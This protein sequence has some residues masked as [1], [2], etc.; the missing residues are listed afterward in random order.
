MFNMNKTCLLVVVGSLTA[1]RAVS[2][3][4]ISGTVTLSGTPPPELEIKQIKDDPNCGKLH[5]AF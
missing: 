3:G 4:D 1:I 2:A 5:T